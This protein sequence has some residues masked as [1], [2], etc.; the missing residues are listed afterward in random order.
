MMRS[1]GLMTKA[2]YSAC[3]QCT[4]PSPD[5]ACGIQYMSADCLEAIQAGQGRQH[6]YE[7]VLSG[8]CGASHGSSEGSAKGRASAQQSRLQADLRSS[9]L[10]SSRR[11]MR[12]RSLASPS[13]IPRRSSAS[14]SSA[15]RFAAASSALLA[16]PLRSLACTLNL[17]EHLPADL[18]LWPK[19]CLCSRLLRMRHF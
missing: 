16:L 17:L 19:N 9:W 2:T 13:R 10:S 6:P 5:L 4:A 14:R 8:P 11:E 18:L 1:Q 12:S 15:A 7:S 3:F